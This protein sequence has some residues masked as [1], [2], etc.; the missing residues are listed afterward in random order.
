MNTILHC[1]ANNFYASV[2]MKL[3]PSLI[4]VPIAV[5]GNHEL[6]HG[7]ILAKSELA[8]KCGVQTGETLWQ[9]KQKCPNIVFVPPHYDE[10]VDFSNKLFDL[11]TEFT[12]KVEPFGID[13][14]WLDCTGST[15][16]FGSGECIADMIRQRV[17]DEL[18]ITISVGVSHTKVLAKL[19]SD[20]K[21]PDATT[22]INVENYREI[23]WTLPVSDLLM[24]GKKT[25]KLFSNLNIKTIGDLAKFDKVLLKKYIGINAEK[26]HCYANGIEFESVKHYYNKHIP[27]SIGNSTT[28]PRDMIRRDEALAIL[29]SLSEM[30]AVRL[31]KFGLL[32][33]GVGLSIKYSSLDGIHKTNLIGFSTSSAE[34]IADEATK[35]LDI[36]HTF[37]ADT[38]IRQIGLST[39][40]LTSERVRQA[41]LFDEGVEKQEKLEQSVDEIRKKYGY[42][43]VQKGIVLKHKDLC[44]GLVDKDFQP[45]KK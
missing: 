35:L 43:S 6:R 28:T 45:F 27:D 15:M 19:G 7:I 11:Y 32:A 5:S 44:H 4:G 18:G 21:K 36:L 34:Q 33:N 40:K 23:A 37:G 42:T 16:L 30:V 13:E 12:D 9:A 8:K 20:Y 3:N 17:K 22:V 41:T 31:R 26:L 10:Y 38:P 1:D 24:V 2:E 14:C 39:Y 29:T 25:T